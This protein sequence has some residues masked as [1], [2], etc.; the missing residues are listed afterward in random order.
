[1]GEGKEKKDVLHFKGKWRPLVL[2]KTNANS[3]AEILGDDSDDWPGGNV[4]LYPVPTPTGDGVRIQA[5]KA[6]IERRPKLQRPSPKGR[7][8]HGG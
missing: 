6:E 7:R 2:N 8:A 3:L 5:C 4:V 1:M